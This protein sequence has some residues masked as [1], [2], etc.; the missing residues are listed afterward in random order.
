M[1]QI[2]FFALPP[3]IKAPHEPYQINGSKMK[4]SKMKA[5]KYYDRPTNRIPKYIK[6]C[7]KYKTY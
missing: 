6:M 5:P 2:L 7:K 4:A 3:Q 1:W